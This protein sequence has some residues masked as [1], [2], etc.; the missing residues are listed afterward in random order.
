[1][2][3][4]PGVPGPR[5]APAEDG[6]ALAALAV[7]VTIVAGAS[8]ALRASLVEP[9]SAAVERRLAGARLDALVARLAHRVA[10]GMGLPERL[11]DLVDDAELRS[12]RLADPTGGSERRFGYLCDQGPFG[13][14]ELWCADPGVAPRR[15]DA[16]RIAARIT[17]DRLGSARRRAMAGLAAGRERELEAALH[18]GRDSLELLARVLGV[19]SDELRDGRGR[20]FRVV[21]GVLRAAGPDGAF[22]TDDDARW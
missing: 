3:L 5:R 16:T 21:S 9:T 6:A 12:G 11:E 4:D 10:T 19:R 8:L 2:V 20:P 1:M 14:A 17:V 7:A 13:Q 15:V 18:G 22:D